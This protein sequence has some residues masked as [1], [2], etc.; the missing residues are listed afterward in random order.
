MYAGI[1]A[2]HEF[3]LH[4]FAQELTNAD[5]IVLAPIYAAR[6]KD[7]GDISSEDI[8]KILESEY[9]KDVHCFSSFGEIEDFLL[10]NCIKDDVL[11][12]MGA[13]DVVKIG[14]DL[15]GE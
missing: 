12:T 8:A 2:V 14:E 4:D 3:L 11:I 9:G 10:E 1:Q 6:E 5:R 15:L 13:G 7:P